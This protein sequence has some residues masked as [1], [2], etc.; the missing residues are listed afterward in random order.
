MAN[1]ISITV[2]DLTDYNMA[3]AVHD[4]VIQSEY[5]KLVKERGAKEVNTGIA[6]NF[7]H[8]REPELS[9]QEIMHRLSQMKDEDIMK[10][11]K[12]ALGTTYNSLNLLGFEVKDNPDRQ[13][14]Y[15]V[16]T[17]VDGLTSD[18]IE[19]IVS[20][21]TRMAQTTKPMHRADGTPQLNRE[22]KEVTPGVLPV[23]IVQTSKDAEGHDMIMPRTI[24]LDKDELFSKK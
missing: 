3:A 11:I 23:A 14:F 6:A 20:V 16:F 15:A 2:K 19:N 21:A 1:T 12:T 8:Q 4:A 9:E 7:L 18:P 13:D 22:G 5:E 17:K 24:E 10:Y